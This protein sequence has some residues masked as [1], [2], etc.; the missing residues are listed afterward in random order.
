ML[1]TPAEAAIFI[2]SKKLKIINEPKLKGY[3][4]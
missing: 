3:L 4:N 1:M 2:E